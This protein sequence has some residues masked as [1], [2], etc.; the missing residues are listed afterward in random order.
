MTVARG[1]GLRTMAIAGAMLGA[2]LA[3]G[4]HLALDGRHARDTPDTVAA[5]VA[6]APPARGSLSVPPPPLEASGPPTTTRPGTAAHH[7][8]AD[9]PTGRPTPLAATAAAH[10]A[11]YRFL[12]RTGTGSD[13]A[14]VLFGRGRVVT[15]QGPGPLDAEHTLE[16][17]ADDHLLIRHLPS[18]VGRMVPLVL[19]RPAVE[20]AAGDPVP[21]AD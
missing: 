11:P 21:E 19:R 10:E 13:A 6:A 2:T 3:G 15:V 12:G 16:H 9:P 17:I 7:R 1:D 14:L 20:P 8:P 18:G 5:P 4:L